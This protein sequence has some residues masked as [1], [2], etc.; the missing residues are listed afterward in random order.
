MEANSAL[1]V[2]LL[3]VALLSSSLFVYV[4]PAL[5]VADGENSW[6]IKA[7]MPK[8]ITVGGPGAASGGVAAVDGKIYVMHSTTNYLYDP[9]N[10]SWTAKTPMPTPRIFFAIAVCQNKIYVM[11]GW[12]WNK[13]TNS[14]AEAINEVYDP[15]TDTWETKAPML[16]ARLESSASVVGDEIYVI[17]GRLQNDPFSNQVY[18]VTSDSWCTKKPLPYPSVGFASVAIGGKIYIMGERSDKA[19]VYFNQIYDPRNDSWSMGATMPKG[20]RYAAAG[21]TTGS[22]ALKRIDLVGG[23]HGGLGFLAESTVQMYDPEKDTW[24]VG[25]PM[26][27]PR[28]GLA[29]AVV[30]DRLYAFG[31]Y[32]YWAPG[33][34]YS[35]VSNNFTEVYTPFGYGTPDP[36]YVLEHTPPKIVLA[37][38]LNGSSTNSTVPLVFSVDK[39]VSWIG[40]SLDGQRNV[41]VTGNVT[42]TGLHSGTHSIIVYANDT[43]GNMGASET[44]IFSVS[45]G[46]PW[47][48]VAVVSAVAVVGTVVFLKRRR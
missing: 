6:E 15:Y 40:Y 9:E 18:N 29:V 23:Y 34:D 32:S 26:P 41:T 27:T 42:L 36:V 47:T 5:A 38:S 20:V 13:T 16:Q 4:E 35:H 31:G 1:S 48:V 28:Y 17:G 37:P 12:S 19:G 7:P 44:M 43:Y 11:G 24:T 30:D 39:A 25:Q 46:F 14:G 8:G 10:D 33:G 3:S 21:V 22:L 2:V 45:E